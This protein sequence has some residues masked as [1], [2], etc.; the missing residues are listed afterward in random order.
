[1]E[2]YVFWDKMPCTLVKVNRRFGEIITSIFRV[3]EEANTP[4][5]NGQQA[6]GSTM[7]VVCF[8]EISIAILRPLQ[9]Y[10]S[11]GGTALYTKR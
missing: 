9:V 10:I 11:V 6:V 8:F 3:E 1:M 5:W 4:T 7:A 2:N